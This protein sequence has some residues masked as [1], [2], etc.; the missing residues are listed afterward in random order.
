MFNIALTERLNEYG[1][2][3]PHDLECDCLFVLA[4]HGIT[5]LRA[6]QLES[7]AVLV[8][9]HSPVMRIATGLGKTLV[10]QAAILLG[11]SL[12]QKYPC[13][14]RTSLLFFPT[15]ALLE[16]MSSRFE[17]LGLAVF[18]PPKID[19]TVTATEPLQTLGNF[20]THTYTLLSEHPPD[21][22][23]VSAEF[24]FGSSMSAQSLRM[25]FADINGPS[26][27]F[28]DEADTAVAASTTFRPSQLK[29]ANC[30]TM[31]PGVLMAVSSATLS[32][33]LLQTSLQFFGP[34][35]PILVSTSLDRP[36]LEV[37]TYKIKEF[38]FDRIEAILN[39]IGSNTNAGQI[40]KGSVLILVSSRAEAESLAVAIREILFGAARVMDKRATSFIRPFHAELSLLEKNDALSRLGTKDCRILCCTEASIGQGI[41]IPSVRLLFLH[42]MPTGVTNFIQA[43]G[44]A[45]RDGL[46]S[47]IFCRQDFVDT[48]KSYKH[49]SAEERVSWRIILRSIWGMSTCMIQPLLNFIEGNPS[50]ESNGCGHCELCSSQVVVRDLTTEVASLL[51]EVKAKPTFFSKKENRHGKE[52]QIIGALS[53]GSIHFESGRDGGAAASLSNDDQTYNIRINHGE[54]GFCICQYSK[55]MT[56]S[57]TEV[58]ISAPFAKRPRT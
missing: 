11:K 42:S 28:F 14:S 8:L 6:H 30:Q 27:I 2:S 56:S 5:E 25:Y 49:V 48:M 37:G 57:E 26:L 1:L 36:N 46:K 7:I 41:D 23:A 17:S 21:V 22:A 35:R 40:D 53:V 47:H 4:P 51:A 19:S 24:F 29:L 16:N 9:G 13:F 10:V 58:S 34:P 38:M 52:L 39:E 33:D 12:P 20:C 15:N 32:P 54:A 18:R 50:I 45:G 55:V 31:Y 3:I 43:I 44:R